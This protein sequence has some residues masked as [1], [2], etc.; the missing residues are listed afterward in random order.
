MDSFC[1]RLPKPKTVKVAEHQPLPQV[2]QRSELAFCLTTV[3]DPE[4][5]ENVT[6]ATGFTPNVVEGPESLGR[7]GAGIVS[8]GM[9]L[10]M[11][12][13][14]NGNMMTG[15]RIPFAMSRDR[16]FF[17]A[18]AQVHHRFHTPSTAIAVQTALAIALML[19]AQSFQRL[20]SL[21]LFAEYVFYMAA[22]ASVFVFRVK[23][24]NASR[25]YR[26]WAYPVVPVLF[27]AASALLLYYSFRADVKYSLAE[28]AM[29]VAGI[30]F[31]LYF[32]AKRS[33]AADCSPV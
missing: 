22:T 19:C 30:P 27:I 28:I 8:V 33:A 25:P 16:C 14:L 1:N 32:A 2:P 3:P 21:T 26:T 15:A 5:G 6:F 13:C 4:A 20:F 31:Y 29:I 9:A 12:V 23:E 18:L 10:S 7:W 17:Y 11:L 24:P